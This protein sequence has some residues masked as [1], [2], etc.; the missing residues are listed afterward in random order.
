MKIVRV[1]L[2]AALSV[3]AITQ[4]PAP[5]SA[6]GTPLSD[7][8]H[9]RLLIG[10]Q[11]M[12]AV[13][14]RL[15]TGGPW[16]S[17][18]QQWVS[19]IDTE[20]ETASSRH[21]TELLYLTADYAF[22]YATY[23]VAGIQYGKSQAQ[24][25]E[26]AKELL[27]KNTVV[28]ASLP[29]YE[30]YAPPLAYDWIAPLLSF[31]EKQQVITW[32]KALNMT[33]D[34][35]PFNSQVVVARS[36][37]LM[38]ALASAGDGVDDSWAQQQIDRYAEFF[39]GPTGVTRSESE[40]VGEDGGAGQG[41]NYGLSYTVP[42]V[43]MAEESWRTA[44]GISE[45][46][47]Y[48]NGERSFIRRLP[49]HFAYTI[50]PWGESGSYPG[51]RRYVLWKSQYMYA[52]KGTTEPLYQAWMTG[53]TGILDTA[54]PEMAS[55]ARWLVANRT[56]SIRTEYPYSALMG[57][58]KFLF[59]KTGAATS[60]EQLG[61]T[62]SR[63]F[64]DGRFVFRTGWSNLNDS[65]V[66][67][68]FNE[69][70]RD[71]WGMTPNYPG[72]FTVDR[73]GPQ[74]IRQGGFS[75]H[76]WGSTSAGPSNILL[77]VD[78]T[79]AAP[80]GAHDDMGGHRIVPGTMRGMVDFVSNGANDVRDSVRYLGAD[81]AAGRDVDYVSGDVTRAYNSV[82]QNDPYNPARVSSL[83]RQFVYFRPERPG[84]DSDLIV[85][86]DRASST[87]VRFEK[88]WLFHTSGEPMVNGTEA[89]GQPVRNG[90]GEGKWTYA[91]AT[92]V[93]ATNTVNGSNG[94]TFLTP[95]LP[96]ARRIVKVGGPNSKGQSWEIDSR[97]FENP[98]GVITP[99]YGV[100]DADT[101]QYIGRYRVEIIPAADAL[102]DVFLNAIE[103]ADSGASTPATAVVLDSQATTTVAAR[104]GARVAV[105]NRQ[106]GNLSS[107]SFT[108]DQGGTYKFHIADLSPLSEYRVDIGGNPL[109]ATASAAGTLYFE[110]SAGSGTTV[111]FTRVGPPGSLD[112][113]IGVRVFP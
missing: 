13:K 84:V 29:T 34:P 78:R 66:T 81:V 88:R 96:A 79:Q 17:D 67:I 106:A 57:L 111:T 6:F 73:K 64:R 32:F 103:V 39:S 18:F 22:V 75:G 101:E 112:P 72:G 108:V 98:F 59:A 71:P 91:G 53:L 38:A 76:D 113:P 95:L 89:V 42:A 85:V 69:W 82:R 14:S 63:Q 8:A 102:A 100:P 5:T 105:F 21:V 110:R 43:L 7:G 93:T 86:Y 56:G 28:H 16:R 50:L 49:Q 2:G 83:V 45:A 4:V 40:L 20:F 90:S 11:N 109:T 26:K 27:L 77:F 97:E 61:L 48:G 9:P 3:L 36:S 52:N 12:T 15:G 54:D 33:T 24:Y 68:T 46:A 25:G 41:N 80:S 44:N 62:N 94:R 99:R 104:I 87:D 47:H 92:R 19:W 1:I 74:V 60:P 30:G 35:N 55:L 37:S 31:S 65:Y 23:P 58:W 107:G 51:G 10:G 70:M